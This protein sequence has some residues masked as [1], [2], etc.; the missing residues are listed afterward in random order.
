MLRHVL[1]TF[2]TVEKGVRYNIRNSSHQHAVS[3]Q[4]FSVYSAFDFG[5]LNV[6]GLT[7]RSLYYHEARSGVYYFLISSIITITLKSVPGTNQY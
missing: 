5:P 4:T 6:C 1:F 2:N 7:G 3:P